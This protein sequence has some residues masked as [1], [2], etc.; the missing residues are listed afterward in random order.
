[1]RKK[2]AIIT[3]LFGIQS[4]LAAM[5]TDISLFNGSNIP[6][7]NLNEN[8]GDTTFFGSENP[9]FFSI[10]RN[11]TPPF[12][13]V[14]EATMSENPPPSALL[15]AM[16]ASSAIDD[17][18]MSERPASSDLLADDENIDSSPLVEPLDL[19]PLNPQPQTGADTWRRYFT[20]KVVPAKKKRLPNCL[21]ME[22][23]LS[24]DPDTLAKRILITYYSST[25]PDTEPEIDCD[26][27]ADE[28][29]NMKNH[30]SAE[31]KNTLAKPI[32]MADYLSTDP[33]QY[34]L[35]PKQ[36]VLLCN[37]CDNEY[38]TIDALNAHIPTHQMV[39]TRLRNQDNQGQCPACQ[40]MLRV[41]SIAGHL[42][43]KHPDYKFDN[44]HIP[45]HQTVMNKLCLQS[46]R[47]QCPVCKKSLL[48]RS[49]AGHLKR[50]HPGYK[51]KKQ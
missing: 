46:D 11:S 13:A 18:A 7:F 12:S 39:M 40:K 36:C 34:T 50:K 22:S 5:E 27:C 35:D 31:N 24:T 49:I 43:R 17:A 47:G 19:Q 1:M 32:L 25:D 37:I 29:K 21:F 28:Y 2:L 9:F 16:P 8:T 4:H 41:D 42:S 45:T 3:C 26:I 15:N 51:F 38:D 20:I 6:Y 44:V 48:V 23:H 14:D 33:K 30:L 10:N